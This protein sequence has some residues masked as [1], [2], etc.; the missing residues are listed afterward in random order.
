MSDRPDPAL[1]ALI[2][3]RRACYRDFRA[4][5]DACEVCSAWDGDEE[6]ARANRERYG[7]DWSDT[8]LADLITPEPPCA[9]HN[10]LMAARFAANDR[11]TAAARALGWN[12]P[13]A[14]ER[15]TYGRVGVL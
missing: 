7:E 11:V 13:S 3:E 15:A 12:S 2:R 6:M 5:A 8:P 1:D 10:R 9:E 14:Y 4:H